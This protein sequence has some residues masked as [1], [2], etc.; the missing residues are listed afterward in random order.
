MPATEYELFKLGRHTFKSGVYQCPIVRFDATVP[1]S[2]QNATFDEL[3]ELP[4]GFRFH[5]GI[6]VASASLGAS[7][8]LAIGTAAD[9]AAYRAAAVFTTVDTPVLFGKWANHSADALT[10]TTV[11]RATYAVAALPALGNGSFSVSFEGV[12]L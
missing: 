9:A 1:F 4:P 6:I 11:V 3:F 8:T 5:K 10:T 2:A 7:A 12:M